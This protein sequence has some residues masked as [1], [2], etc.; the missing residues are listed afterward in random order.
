[1]KKTGI[2]GG[3]AGQIY[4]AGRG[5]PSSVKRYLSIFFI[6]TLLSGAIFISFYKTEESPVLEMEEAGPAEAPLLEG[7]SVVPAEEDAIAG[8][9]ESGNV[10][11]NSVAIRLNREGVDLLNSDRFS[12]AAGKLY[13]ALSLYPTSETIKNNLAN[14]YLGAGWKSFEGK[15]YEKARKN[16]NRSIDVFPTASAYKGRG[17]AL[18]ETGNRSDALADIEESILLDKDDPH[19]HLLMGSLLYEMNRL[20]EAGKY[21][22]SALEINPANAGAAAF[23]KK[24]KREAVEDSFSGAESSNFFVKYEGLEN[25]ET[26][27]LLLMV[28]EEAYHKVGA[29]IGVYPEKPVTVI[30]YS[31]L[32]FSDVTRSPAWAGGLYDGKIRLPSGGISQKT[33]EL[34]RVVYHEYTHALVHQATAGNC[35]TWLNE[36]LA[37]LEEGADVSRAKNFI[38]RA[39]GPLPL[40]RLEKSFMQL[41]GSAAEMAYATSLLAVDYIV[42]QYS[43]AYIKSILE[44]LGKGETIS[45]A[46][47]SALYLSYGDIEKSFRDSL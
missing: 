11:D 24:I 14:A 20:E 17:M 15:D 33:G 44:L 22:E 39:G 10:K 23:L 37:Q 40:G 43:Y 4:V 46:I 38:Q 7:T 19:T 29:D 2:K 35:P 36:G 8:V 26:G 25:V 30:L 47:R 16:F 31:D 34:I 1:M 45:G 42:S 5:R 28:L 27:Y 21:F 6:L 12:E 3:K 41:E 32:Q 9:L 18:L 13:E